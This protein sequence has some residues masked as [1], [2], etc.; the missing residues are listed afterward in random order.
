V[1]RKVRLVTA[2]R[3]NIPLFVLCLLVV[4]LTSSTAARPGDLPTGCTVG[5][6]TN[7]FGTQLTLVCVPQTAQ[8]NG[9]LVIY[10]HGYVSPEKPLQLPLDELTQVML[11]GTTVIGFL[12][13]QGFAFATTSY[14][15]NGYAVENAQTDLNQVVAE[16]SEAL[17]AKPMVILIGASAGGVIA[18]QQLERFPEIYDGGLSLCGPLGGM[19]YQIE[20]VGD[21]RVVFDHFFQDVFDFGVVDIPPNAY[22]YWLDYES[23]IQ[24]VIPNDPGKTAQLF[25]VTEAARLAWEPV[26]GVE[27]ALSLLHF[28]V[29]STDDV[30]AV[31]GGNPYGNQYTRYAGSSDDQALNRQV[32]RVSADP[33]AQE[34]LEMYYKPTGDLHVPLVTMHTLFD[35]VVPF[36]H[37]VMYREVAGGSG[38]LTVLPVARYG[39]CAFTGEEVFG[40]FGLLLAK[41]GLLP[42]STL[43]SHI[44]SLPAPME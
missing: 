36:H 9:T 29:F 19:P 32:E 35:G 33:E 25:S 13:G 10:A 22:L 37:E 12:L 17:S 1:N 7:A 3:K 11:G 18:V 30:T 31:A 41:M 15:A 16:A 42:P 8:W 39:H 5:S 6:L 40:A 14:S 20:Y 28:S 27:T 44:Q 21:F 26:T 38:N 4:G 23:D 34:Y 2:A 43:V 24:D